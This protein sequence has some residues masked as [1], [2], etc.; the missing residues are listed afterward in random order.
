MKMLLRSC[1]ALA[2]L[3]ALAA[4]APCLADFAITYDFSGLTGNEPGAPV[5]AATLP[6]GVTASDI[7]RGPGLIPEMGDHS[8]NSRDWKDST[9]G[10]YYE[11]TVT[12][13]AGTPLDLS[14]L[15]YTDRR[16][17]TGPANFTLAFSLDGFATS[18]VIGGYTLTDQAN[19][20]ETFDLSGIADLQNPTSPVTFRI[21]GSGARQRIGT[22]RLGIAEGWPNANLPANLVLTGGTAVPEP[23]SMLL[24]GLGA[25]GMAV[26]AAR[27]RAA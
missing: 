2:A 6:P 17:T 5:D 19:Y 10:M 22:Y 14:Q 11:F 1:R 21:F 26:V 25:I 13:A 27:R 24:V 12:P 3:V 23:A 8:L 20:R 9:G 16:S 4:P 7:T 18:N 15:A